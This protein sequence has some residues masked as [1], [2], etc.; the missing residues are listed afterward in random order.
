LGKAF[1]YDV[2]LTI[3]PTSRLS[4]QFSIDTS[5]FTDARINQRV[6]DVKILRTFTTYQF[7]NRLLVRNILE[8]NT[9]NGKVGVNLLITYRVNAGTVFYIGYDDRL[10]EGIFLDR[11]RFYSHQLQRQRRAFF[12]KFQFLFRY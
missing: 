6:F 10:Q 5:R 8:H 11:D 2:N 4:T 9:G 7:T 3:L 1:E 12:T